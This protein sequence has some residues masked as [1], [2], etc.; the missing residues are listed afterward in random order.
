MRRFDAA[1]GR[2]DVSV[3]GGEMEAMQKGPAQRLLQAVGP[4][5]DPWPTAATIGDGHIAF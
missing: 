4:G 2:L 3:M 1:L 5:P